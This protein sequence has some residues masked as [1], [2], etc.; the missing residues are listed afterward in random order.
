M[1]VPE[2]P[3][4]IYNSM[5]TRGLTILLI[6]TIR[7][8]FQ[9][10]QLCHCLIIASVL[11]NIR[12]DQWF[13]NCHTIYENVWKCEWVLQQLA[14]PS[15]L[16]KVSVVRK[17]P[18]NSWLLLPNILIDVDHQTLG[19]A[20]SLLSSVL[21]SPYICTSVTSDASSLRSFLFNC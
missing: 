18:G 7:F 13:D 12:S 9:F 6:W 14:N 21:L 11:V 17:T 3:T 2:W 4:F 5:W 15:F 10:K 1:L 8:N 20:G 16:R 19:S